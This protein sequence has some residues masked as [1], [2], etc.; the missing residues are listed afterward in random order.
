MNWGPHTEAY[1]GRARALAW[2]KYMR[3]PVGWV[4][5]DHKETLQLIVQTCTAKTLR[6]LIYAFLK[7]TTKTQQATKPDSLRKWLL[8]SL[9][10]RFEKIISDCISV[11][12]SCQSLHVK[13]PMP[14]RKP[15]FKLEG[16][17]WSLLNELGS[18]QECL[19]EAH[20]SV[21]N[22]KKEQTCRRSQLWQTTKKHCDW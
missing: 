14:I 8:V 4:S 19:L 22:G 3:N 13:K 12:K 15:A 5:F 10:E 20:G 21:R 11:C 18:T 1:T 2:W 9:A 7:L 16:P 17:C 6:N